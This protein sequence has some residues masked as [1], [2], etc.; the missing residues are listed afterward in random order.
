MWNIQFNELFSSKHCLSKLTFISMFSGKIL[1]A[2]LDRICGS[3]NLPYKIL[4]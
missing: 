3:K 1:M 2:L 4:L